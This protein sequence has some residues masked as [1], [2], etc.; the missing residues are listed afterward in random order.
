MPMDLE[1][2]RRGFIGLAAAGAAAALPGVALAEDPDSAT[3]GEGPLPVIYIVDRIKARPGCGREVYDRY[4]ARFE[5]LAEER[6]MELD[7]AVIAP[8]IWLTDDVSSN[9]LEF[10]WRV[11]GYP[12][13][14][15]AISYGDQEAVAWWDEIEEM[16]VGRDRSYFS[17][18]DD[19]E[20]LC[21]V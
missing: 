11:E 2:D 12:A 8:P 14:A 15:G 18:A 7:R 9:T 6:G 5:P 21:N 13:F 4:L 16:A 17:T 19:L 1:L 3:G 10:V 20:V